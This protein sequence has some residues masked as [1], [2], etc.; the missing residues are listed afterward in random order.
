MPS[1]KRF[2][3]VGVSDVKPLGIK[4]YGHIPHLPGSRMGPADHCCHSG[5]A[6]I[7]T[8]Q[9]R[10]RHDHVTVTVKL[11]GSCVAVAK[12]D[13]VIVPLIRAGWPA[14][15]SR[16]EQHVLFHHWA[17]RN[18]ARFLE[19]LDN[20]ER[21]IGEWLAQAHGTRYKL[22]HEPFVAFDLMHGGKRRLTGE[23]RE[24]CEQAGFA[25]PYLIHQGD[26][27]GVPEA[28]E[29]IETPR[30]GEIDPVEGCVWRV[31]RN[32]K[33]DF[34]VKY[35]RP[36]KIDGKYLHEISGEPD[37]WNWRLQKE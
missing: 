6:A 34:I 29:A 7:A 4:A 5:Q 13:H 18:Q 9:K 36:D 31:E 32:G 33:C 1:P 21:V 12:L 25:V 28:L 35:V 10:D 8:K 26:A 37:I 27:F 24:R 14:A 17:M 23:M 16:R 3:V 22:H 2:G 30:H 15:S 20:E 11:D 19:L